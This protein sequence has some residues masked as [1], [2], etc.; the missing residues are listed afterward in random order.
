MNVGSNPK[1]GLHRPK[2]YIEATVGCNNASAAR[3][4]FRQQDRQL[5]RHG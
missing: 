4:S 2:R 1:K 3:A 5:D